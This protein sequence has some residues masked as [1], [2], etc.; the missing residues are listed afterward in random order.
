VRARWLIGGSV[1]S[2]VVLLIG[3]MAAS[4]TISSH[5][6]EAT[7][8][9]A[10]VGRLDFDSS[11]ADVTIRSGGPAVTVHRRLGWS[12]GRP[13]VTERRTGAT[14]SLHAVCGGDEGVHF[15]VNCRIEYDIEVPPEADIVV[16]AQSISVTGLTGTLDLKAQGLITVTGR[17]RTLTA[18]SS[19]GQV[20]L[21]P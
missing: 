4:G 7:V 20:D 21:R 18:R 2:A 1:Y 6:T 3:M 13:I 14:L 17:P 10:G 12:W 8:T 9:H 19:S 5:D 15:S 11:S 16:S